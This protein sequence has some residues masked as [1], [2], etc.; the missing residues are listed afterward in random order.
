MSPCPGSLPGVHG[1]RAAGA[2]PLVL[3]RISSPLLWVLTWP[4]ANLGGGMFC[5]LPFSFLRRTTLVLQWTEDHG[6]GRRCTWG[7]WQSLP[8]LEVCHSQSWA[9]PFKLS[10]GGCVTYCI[11]LRVGN[12][13]L[14]VEYLP[15]VHEA[16]GL[17]P[18]PHKPGVVIQV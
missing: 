17:A 2:R 1:N 5:L 15:T 14:W 12:V 7:P 9:G 4:Q 16:L 13:A 8:G 3:V 11:K 18:S 6:V 10:N